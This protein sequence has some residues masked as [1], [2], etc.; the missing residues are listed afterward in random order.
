MI[1]FFFA[2]LGIAALALTARVIWPLRSASPR[3]FIALILSAPLLLIAL[4]QITGTPQALVPG[5]TQAPA[6]GMPHSLEAAI[7]QL[8]QSLQQHPDQPEG[9]ALLARSYA[10]LGQ[11]TRARDAWA[12]ALALAP[13]NAP[14]FSPEAHILRVHVSLAPTLAART[15][16]DP[17]ASIFVFARIPDGPP[18]PVAVERLRL[19]ELPTTLTLDDSSS[20]MPTQR[21]SDLGEA[22]VLARLSAS[23]SA[24]RQDADIDSGTIRVTLPHTA[25]ITLVIGDTP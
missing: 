7:A 10:A 4:Y 17:D 2:L 6:D 19:A 15:D 18:M 25:T 3:L 24:V 12:R 13:D 16:L 22:E 23:G 9:W 11:L 14:A 20:P 5:A 8:E 1:P 21:L